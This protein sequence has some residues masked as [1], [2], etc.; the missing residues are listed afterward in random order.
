MQ[1]FKTKEYM[2]LKYLPGEGGCLLK[3]ELHHE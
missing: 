1:D 3:E 2:E